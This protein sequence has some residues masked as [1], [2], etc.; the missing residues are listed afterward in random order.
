MLPQMPASYVVEA[1]AAGESARVV[2]ICWMWARLAR[3]ATSHR[4]VPLAFVL[5]GDDTTVEPAGWPSR[6]LSATALLHLN[7]LIVIYS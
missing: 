1:R 2:P 5:L 6:V 4:D 7:S 3:I